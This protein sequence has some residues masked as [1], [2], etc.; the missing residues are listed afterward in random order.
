MRASRRQ[1][2]LLLRHVIADVL[3]SF[4]NWDSKFFATIGRLLVRPWKL[5]NQFLAKRLP[6]TEPVP[7]HAQD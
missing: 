1:L 6:S 4:L 7:Q 2:P 5:T 3:D